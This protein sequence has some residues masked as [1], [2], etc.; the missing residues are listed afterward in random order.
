MIEH[1]TKKDLGFTIYDDHHLEKV[2][3]EDVHPNNHIAPF[4]WNE[5][6]K[7]A[8]FTRKSYVIYWSMN[9][10]FDHIEGYVDM[11]TGEVIGG[12]YHGV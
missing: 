6:K 10:D 12:N 4:N 7:V 1:T 5:N 2:E 3:I 8:E 11:Y 9:G